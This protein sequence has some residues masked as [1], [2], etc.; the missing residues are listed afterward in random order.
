MMTRLSLRMRIFLFFCLLALGGA[1]IVG[2]SLYA[3]YRRSGEPAA[4]DAFVFSGAISIFA[5]VAMCAGIWLL[6]DENVA[7]PI[8][9][10][11]SE[12]GSASSNQIFI[13]QINL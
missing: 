13:N 9:R 1:A 10:L 3:G 6:F 8:E 12:R 7:R 2:L 4:L 5:L 11:A